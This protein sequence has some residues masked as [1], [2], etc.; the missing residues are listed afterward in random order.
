MWFGGKNWKGRY[1]AW[2]HDIKLEGRV[3]VQTCPA[4][5]IHSLQPAAS[6]L[7]ELLREERLCVLREHPGLCNGDS[8]NPERHALCCKYHQ[9]IGELEKGRAIV[10]GKG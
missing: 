1:Q 6:D 9:E 10:G 5:A 3:E 4:N 8:D 7:E 2:V